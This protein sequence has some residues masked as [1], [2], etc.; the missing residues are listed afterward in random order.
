MVKPDF[1]KMVA[2]VEG[3]R[4]VHRWM[5]AWGK[6]QLLSLVEDKNGNLFYVDAWPDGSMFDIMA[7]DIDGHFAEWKE[8]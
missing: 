4:V 3:G 7:V 1:N 6:I 2:E 5:E 8:D